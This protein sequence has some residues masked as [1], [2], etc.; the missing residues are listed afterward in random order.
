MKFDQDLCLNLQY[1]FGKM[2][3]TLGSVVPLAMFDI[4]S[5]SF[6]CNS[7]LYVARSILI[8]SKVTSPE[9]HLWMS[10]GTKVLFQVADSCN[11]D[12]GGGLTATNFNGR[13]VGNMCDWR[14]A[15][16]K[17]QLKL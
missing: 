1:D 2:N 17:T 16:N 13:E 9:L 7:L 11:G 8:W 10:G 4:Y 14:K 3:S 12:S 5:L 15:T 6:F